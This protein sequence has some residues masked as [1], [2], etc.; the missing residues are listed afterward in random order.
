MFER[1]HRVKDGDSNGTP[2]L[3]IGLYLCRELAAGQGG[4]IWVESTPGEG[5]TFFF[6]LPAWS[7]AANIRDAIERAQR[8]PRGVP[9]LL[10]IV[11]RSSRSSLPEELLEA[12]GS[13]FE[14]R[15][16]DLL[17]PRSGT[18]PYEE[19]FRALLWLANA[20]AAEAVEKRLRGSLEELHGW[21]RSTMTLE[22]SFEALADEHGD[23]GG[24]APRLLR[25]LASSLGNR[26]EGVTEESVCHE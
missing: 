8:Q 10:S 12:V 11:V 2:G 14:L 6:T 25:L 16:S 26:A 21:D 24:V 5:S 3:G 1:L 22:L 4:K 23:L 7:L 15:S 18:G 9:T 17:L 19:T 13:R 20:R